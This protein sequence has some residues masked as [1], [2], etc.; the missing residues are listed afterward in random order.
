MIGPPARLALLVLVCSLHAEGA[1]WTA[2][3]RDCVTALAGTE[4]PADPLAAACPE[5]SRALDADPWSELLTVPSDELSTRSVV[6]LSALAEYYRHPPPGT[7]LD[8]GLLDAVLAALPE[9]GGE[10]PPSLWERLRRWLLSMLEEEDDVLPAWLEGLALPDGAVE[11]VWYSAVIV[12]VL[13]ALAILVNEIRLYSRRPFP[14]TAPLSA[15]PDDVDLVAG[16][17]PGG[18]GAREQLEALF[19]IMV[20]RLQAIGA[21]PG[22]PSL[23][24]REVAGARGLSP[25]LQGAVAT[26]SQAAERVV[27]GAWSP[28]PEEAAPVLDAGRRLLEDLGGE[29][30]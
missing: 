15:T 1:S 25:D 22:R 10:E 29:S 6:E 24:H 7:R 19:G 28:R 4:E 9:A 16:Q 5:A 14:G 26:L 13:L 27:Y 21:L 3:S 20:G 17:Q 2:L 12:I 11:W 18:D 23:T 8:P 30:A